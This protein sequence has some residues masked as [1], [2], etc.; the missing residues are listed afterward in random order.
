MLGTPG[1]RAAGTER[2]WPASPWPRGG[3]VSRGHHS[4]QDVWTPNMR[5]EAERQSREWGVIFAGHRSAKGGTCGGYKGLSHLG[6]RKTKDAVWKWVTDMDPSLPKTCGG[7]AR[8]SKDAPPTGPEGDAGQN[9]HPR[10]RLEAEGQT[11]ARAAEDG[12]RRKPWCVA[13]GGG[14]CGCRRGGRSGCSSEHRAESHT[15]QRSPIS[16][17]SPREMGSDVPAGAW[18]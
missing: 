13:G 18:T 15:A 6:D 16:V 5:K 12:E 14:R 8:P 1:L 17:V 9:P 3:P 10:G 4:E 11:V 2:G 7:P